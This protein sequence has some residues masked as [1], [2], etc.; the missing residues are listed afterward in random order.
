MYDKFYTVQY[1][2]TVQECDA[3]EAENRTKARFKNI[4]IFP[5]RGEG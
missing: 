5:F 2:D 4:P 1:C 3:Y